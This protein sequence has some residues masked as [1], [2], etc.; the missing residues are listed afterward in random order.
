MYSTTCKIKNA[1][2]RPTVSAS[3]AP[4]TMRSDFF[5]AQCANVTVTLLVTRISVLINGKP[6][7][8]MASVSVPPG[9]INRGQVSAKLGCRIV[10]VRRLLLEPAS[11]G[12]ETTRA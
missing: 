12:T 4:A 5:N 9:V 1:V 11:H 2:P 10:W 7:A 8:P 6:H 3:Q